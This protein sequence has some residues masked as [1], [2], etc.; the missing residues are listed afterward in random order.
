[1]VGFPVTFAFNDQVT[2]AGMIKQVKLNLSPSGSSGTE[3]YAGYFDEEY[4]SKLQADRGIEVFDQMRRSDGQVKMLLSVVKNPIKSA[5]WSVQ[6]VDETEAEAE[7]AAFAEHVLRDM[8]RPFHEFVSEALTMIEFGFSLF[9]IVHKRVNSHKQFGDYLGIGNLAFRHQR[10]ILEWH[11]NDDGS[12]RN[13][14]QMAQG[15]LDRDVLLDGRFLL[16]FTNEKEGDNYEGISMLRP[17]YGAWFRKNI[18]RKIQAIGIER[19]AKGVAVGTVP[20]EMINRSDY[21]AQLNSF[22][23]LL[24]QL[25]SHAKN[26]IALGAGFDVKELKIT[27]DAE[28]VQ[29][30]INSENVEMSKAFLANFM[31][32]GLEQNGGSYSLG[33]DLSDIFLS[34]IE[35]IASGLIC[36]K[37]NR[38]VIKPIVRAKYGEREKYP[39]MTVKGINDKAGKELAE[40][41]ASL[42][43]EGAIQVS[44]RLQKYVH[45]VY[46]L[47][48]LD[49]DLAAAETERLL[50][51]PAPPPAQLPPP[52]TDKKKL[53]EPHN[54]GTVHLSETQ[55]K[56]FPVSAYIE[57]QAD[58]LYKITR[59]GLEQ[60]SQA[61][62]D[63]MFA[64]MRAGKNATVVR[65]LVLGIG[66]P[67]AAEYRAQIEQ[68]AA[69]TATGTIEQT[70]K[71][72]GRARKDVKLAEDD[73]G[74]LPPSIRDRIVQSV[75]LATGYQ[76][77]DI[78]KA[79]YFA[80]NENYLSPDD[81]ETTVDVM[82]SARERYFE[83]N[84]LES[85]A[86]TISSN[87]VNNTRSEVFESDNVY[88]D[89]ES[90]VFENPAPETD[91][92]KSLV[93]TVFSVQ[94][95]E[96]SAYLPPVHFNCKSYLRAQTKGAKGN[97]SVNGKLDVTDP[98]L[99]KQA[100]LS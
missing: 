58:K 13:V 48:T 51:P 3:I 47:P 88:G 12:I 52:A 77:A 67:D 10:T 84:A 96:T 24:D 18:Y 2:R 91:V 49:E 9:E 89:I 7:I 66:M 75:L 37:L 31:E 5:T 82:K 93:G 44:P 23:T 80:F 46:G 65:K 55:R 61:M 85:G 56:D 98:R 54:C 94:D 38:E 35:F 90:F 100:N 20:A 16:V 71:E 39:E 62:L 33:S 92:C 78:E 25:A 64:V 36:E 97:V 70:L 50:N 99:I 14:R 87:V 76:D 43:R 72:L 30:V 8:R 32:L 22:Q 40:I 41:I 59:A 27:H 11:L 74:A 57:D 95:Y 53:S 45:E 69:E 60:R 79:V 28:K 21:A 6:A 29:S 4:L 73:I 17:C 26:N 63:K 15:D 83:R 19:A 86:T 42:I 1:M 68:W 34:G 81:L